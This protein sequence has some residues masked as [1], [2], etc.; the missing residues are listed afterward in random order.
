MAE[1]I[2]CK[3]EEHLTCSV[4]LNQL[5]DPKVLPCLHSYCYACIVNLAKSTKSSTFNCPDCR[6]EV[7]VDENT[8][9]S[10][11][12]N[13][14][15]NN[16]LATMMLTNEEPATKKILCD[17]CDSEDDAQSR[18]SECGL[19]LCQFCTA[20][21]KR[22][23]STK[24]HELLTF[25]EIK[26]NPG[27]QRIAEKI[28]CPKH[29]GEVIKLFCK[30][31]QETICRD[32]TIVDHRQH[33]YGFVE[34]VADEEKANIRSNLDEVKERK[35]RV[36]QGIVNIQD[37][38]KRVEKKRQSTISEISEHFDELTK[39][40]ENQKKKMIEKSTMHTNSKQKQIHAQLEVL[41]VALA[42]CES[43]IEFTEQA[44]KNG[45]DVQI[46]SMEKY[47]LQSLEQLKAVK[48]QT[49][50]SVTEDMLFIIPSSVEET[51]KNLLNEYDVDVAVPSP[52]NCKVSFQ[53]GEARFIPGNQYSIELLCHDENNRRLRYG[54]HDIKPSF[55][56][57]EVS[58]VAV[59]DNND[60]SY[61]IS[62]YPR[63][64]GGKVKFEASING[65]P[66]PNC[67]LIRWFY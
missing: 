47:I 3:V 31:C 50:P 65:I 11:P 66:A 12:T 5:K 42:S 49:T 10:L 16:L 39:A 59:A 8:I 29:K 24:H 19:F 55:T 51:K 56:G 4:C 67:S 17:S 54:G 40:V 20:S 34:D 64:L 63:G 13:F 52:G 44:F 7:K 62:F 1:S 43:S 41:E 25:A 60:G 26:S 30:T 18:C 53:Q 57:M 28:R 14:F 22:M 46:L 45:N 15:I 35:G 21:H 48:D 27:P 58:D 6:L 38:K 33:E 37:F 23:R 36:I 32:C 2:R 61:V 9:S